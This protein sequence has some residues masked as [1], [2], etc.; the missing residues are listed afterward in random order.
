MNFSRHS[1]VYFKA[2]HISQ[3]NGAIDIYRYLPRPYASLAVMI[4]GGWDFREYHRG[5]PDSTGHA[6][7]GDLLFVPMGATYDGVWECGDGRVH[8]ISLHF[9]L[10]EIGIFGS[11]RSGVQAIR[12]EDFAAAL[13]NP[14]SDYTKEFL[15]IAEICDSSKDNPTARERFE[16]MWRFL[17]LLEATIPCLTRRDETERDTVLDPALKYLKQNFTSPCPVPELARLCNLSDS[18]FFVRFKRAYNFFIKS[19]F[20]N[21]RNEIGRVSFFKCGVQRARN[22]VVVAQIDRERERNYRHKRDNAAEC[23]LFIADIFFKES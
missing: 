15:R 6:G 23:T 10:D 22:I 3:K 2:E 16:L 4:Y 8:I 13:G 9:E 1:V 5:E 19:F 18:Q 17:R 12:G 11:Q 14:E 7:V 21:D 20:G